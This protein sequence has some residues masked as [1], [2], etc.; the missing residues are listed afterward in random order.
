M[1]GTPHY[2]AG[3]WQTYAP[4][5]PVTK[6]ILMT[7]TCALEAPLTP[8]SQ[9][10]VALD[11]SSAM[12]TFAV[13]SLSPGQSLSLPFGSGPPSSL[14]LNIPNDGSPDVQYQH[15]METTQRL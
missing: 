6:S 3:Q 2:A 10:Y 12:A 4:P 15:L 1:L 11:T 5:N 8:L 13:G 9:G 14:H 7:A